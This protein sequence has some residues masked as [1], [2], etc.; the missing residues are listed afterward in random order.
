MVGLCR[1]EAMWDIQLKEATRRW[2]SFLNMQGEGSDEWFMS[3]GRQI[4]T[5]HKQGYYN[6]FSAD[7]KI[8]K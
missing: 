4:V 2:D 1:K 6:G 8:H 5:Q 3:M 7:S